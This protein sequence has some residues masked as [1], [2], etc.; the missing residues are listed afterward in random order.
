[1]VK[2]I[3]VGQPAA[4]GVDIDL[5]LEPELHAEEKLSNARKRL[6]D[7]CLALSHGNPAVPIFL[8]V[9]RNQG[10]SPDAWLEGAQYIPLAASLSRPGGIVSQ[11]PASFDFADVKMKSLSK[12]LADSLPLEKAGPSRTLPRWLSWLS[13]LAASEAPLTNVPSFQM[14]KFY[15]DFSPLDALGSGALGS[16]KV[17]A[18]SAEQSKTAFGDKLVLLGDAP[19]SGGAT[20]I[21]RI[22]GYDRP[23]PGVLV[24]GCGALTL[25]NPLREIIPWAGF[26]LAIIVSLAGISLIYFCCFLAARHT[27][28]TPVPLTILMSVALI[29]CFLL[30]ASLLTKNYRVLWLEV[31]VACAVLVTH[32]LADVF[33]ASVNWTRLRRSPHRVVRALVSVAHAEDKT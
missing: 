4:I 12:A 10:R 8:G 24:H 21:A 30:L 11:L 16:D 2:R 1:V 25:C 17:M 7:E 27:Q 29:V 22:V 32:C 15:V 3:A 13:R 18:L 26:T 20:D 23:V 31:F 9:G 33:I 19:P 14:H 5:S 28:V 6:F